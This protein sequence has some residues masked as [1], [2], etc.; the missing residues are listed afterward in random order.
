MC[1]AKHK[2]GGCGLYTRDNRW[3]EWFAKTPTKAARHPAL[4]CEGQTVSPSLVGQLLW[5]LA[6]QTCTLTLVGIVPCDVVTELMVITEHTCTRTKSWKDCGG[7]SEGEGGG[8][9]GE[10]CDKKWQLKK[11]PKSVLLL[12]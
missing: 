9:E 6:Q 10:G 4:L 5:L 8:M 7:E 12:V 11:K 1:C 3:A 2:V